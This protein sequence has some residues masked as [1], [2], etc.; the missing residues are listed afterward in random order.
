MQTIPFGSTSKSLQDAVLVTHKLGLRYLWVDSMCIIQD[1]AS[2]VAREISHM[3]K[4][5]QKA[6]VT[7]SAARAASSRQGFLQD[8]PTPSVLNP[9][10]RLRYCCPDGLIGSVVL[11]EDQFSVQSRGQRREPIEERAWT[12]QESFLSPRML[13]F[14]S[15]G[16]YWSCRTIHQDRGFGFLH[17]RPYESTATTTNRLRF[18]NVAVAQ[19][20]SSSRGLPGDTWL[21]MVEQYTGRKL[22]YTTDKL[23]AIAG[24][25][26]YYTKNMNDEYIAGHFRSSF[27][28]S[29]LWRRDAARAPLISRSK[30]YRAPSWSWPAA[31]GEVLWEN[32]RSPTMTALHFLSYNVELVDPRLPYGSIKAASIQIR[33]RIREAI[34]STDRRWIL[35]PSL[36]GENKIVAEAIPDVLEEQSSIWCLEICGIED[37]NRDWAMMLSPTLT[38][39]LILVTKDGSKFER[40]GM[41]RLQSPV[42]SPE[43]WYRTM[44][45]KEEREHLC[46]RKFWFQGCIP[47][48]ITI[49]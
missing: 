35:D 8:Y 3:P 40:Q 43:S 7:I 42:P 13:V 30:T 22:T 31:E 10:F 2:D 19:V 23:P 32:A 39:G 44:N 9:S 46:L 27:L 4:I 48:A 11:T 49:I 12:L 29:L 24:L 25:A 20:A 38:K 21:T 15:R 5:Y 36:P 33:G 6:T 45:T 18:R 14:G 34:W 16:V 1:D 28:S 37:R 17:P 41:F 26:E 47:R